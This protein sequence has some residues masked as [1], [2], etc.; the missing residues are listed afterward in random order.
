M[1]RKQLNEDGTPSDEFLI[2][3]EFIAMLDYYIAASL[4]GRLVDAVALRPFYTTRV[5][6]YKAFNGKDGA[7]DWRSLLLAQLQAWLTAFP[8]SR[9]KRRNRFS[10]GASPTQRSEVVIDQDD[11]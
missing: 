6:L 8:D 10:V 1:N 7:R 4:S 11:L 5:A 2:N 3:E 9:N